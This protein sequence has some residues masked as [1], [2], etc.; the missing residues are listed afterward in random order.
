MYRL[1]AM[2]TCFFTPQG[3]YDLDAR[4]AITAELGFDA[5]YLTLNDAAWPD[6]P[7]L[8]GV[9]ARHG[10][11]VAAVY[12][13]VRFGLD[14]FEDEARTREL[15]ETI[16]CCRTIELAVVG[17][18]GLEPSDPAGDST[19][20]RAIEPW[21]RVADRRDLTLVLYPHL[22][23]WIERLEDATRLCRLI[24]HPHLKAVFCGF[25]W[26]AKDGRDL[27]GTLAE[28]AGY[29]HHANLSGCDPARHEGPPKRIVPLDDGELDN[30]Y[31]LAALRDAGLVEDAWLG[32]Q[33]YSVAGDVYAKLRRSKAALD[34]MLGRLKRHPEWAKRR[35]SVPAR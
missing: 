3:V 18:G 4:C 17:V 16:A 14:G 24:D 6:L 2:D 22:R 13:P 7:R 34:D 21:L 23:N 30:F 25:H 31:V 29:L 33:G 10:L 12:R 28:A 1:Y 32:V 9:R 27:P 8:D 15:L 19:F 20:A 35:V 5:T 26:Y 11:D